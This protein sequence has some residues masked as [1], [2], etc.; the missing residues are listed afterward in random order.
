MAKTREIVG[1]PKG[2]VALSQFLT[3]RTRNL[4]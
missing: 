4:S 1:P 3:A 2:M